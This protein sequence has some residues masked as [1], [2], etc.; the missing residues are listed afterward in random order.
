MSGTK[1][2]E[3]DRPDGL[4]TVLQVSQVYGVTRSAVGMWIADG[5]PVA[6]R[7]PSRGSPHLLDLEQVRA[8]KKKGAKELDPQY[9][10]AM[11][12]RERRLKVTAERM[13]LEG[14]L[15]P[16]DA[17]Q[18][19]W[20]ALVAAARA[21]FLSLPHKLAPAVVSC[22]TLREVEDEARRIVNEALEELAGN[23][24][25]DLEA[26]PEPDGESM[27]GQV[28]EVVSGSECGTGP[29]ADGE[30]QLSEGNP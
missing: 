20:S 22:E 1:K 19:H 16:T 2:I 29:V 15:I 21:K 25:P 24:I 30:G 12:D 18:E 13:V 10:K 28:P 5:C 26:T 9:E 23:G 4:L 7:S 17:V 8:W 6:I 11:L 27:G 3:S 14:K